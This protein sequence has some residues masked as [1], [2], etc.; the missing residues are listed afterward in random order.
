MKVLEEVQITECWSGKDQHK[1]RNIVISKKIVI[2]SPTGANT[3]HVLL[4]VKVWIQ[5]P[6]DALMDTCHPRVFFFFLFFIDSSVICC[7]AW[8]GLA[9]RRCSQSLL[10]IP[11]GP[12][13]SVCLTAVL[14]SALAGGAWLPLS[15]APGTLSHP[16]SLASLCTTTAAHRPLRQC[17]GIP[18]AHGGRLHQPPGHWPETPSVGEESPKKYSR[19][20]PK[21]LAVPLADRQNLR[22][23]ESLLVLQAEGACLCWA[24]CQFRPAEDAQ[25]A[26]T[27]EIAASRI[28]TCGHPYEH[29]SI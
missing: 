10:P 20:P 9:L 8:G 2:S 14:L 4:N 18:S 25:D 11:H 17:S 13:C 24:C 27:E 22:G 19:S 29:D 3:S 7:V 28:C 5:T 26:T 12:D 23:H 16:L 6:R 15:G 1:K 21:F